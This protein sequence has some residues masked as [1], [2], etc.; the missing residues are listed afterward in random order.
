MSAIASRNLAKFPD[1]LYPATPPPTMA[2]TE[3]KACLSTSYPG[4]QAP[5]PPRSP[6]PEV[7]T[8]TDA[9]QD[10]RGDGDDTPPPVPPKADSGSGAPAHPPPK[11]DYVLALC[12]ILV[13][14]EI[15]WLIY[16]VLRPQQS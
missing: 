9:E 6:E 4:P 7:E 2:K 8:E 11:P 1:K 13:Y 15:A 16:M 10:G 3:Q 12:Y 14:L 5:T